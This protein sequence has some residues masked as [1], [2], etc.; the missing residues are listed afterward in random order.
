MPR[1]RGH[2]KKKPGTNNAKQ[3]AARDAA[4]ALRDERLATIEEEPEDG[5]D[6]EEAVEEPP[7]T[8]EQPRKKQRQVHT[9]WAQQTLKRATIQYF[10]ERLCCPP[11]I[12]ML[13]M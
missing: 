3:A 12:A 13:Q 2:P 9:P 10:Y 11:E 7:E 5:E 6:G 8:M 1:A 4:A